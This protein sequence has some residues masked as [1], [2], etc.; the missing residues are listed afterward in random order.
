MEDF[1]MLEIVYRIYEVAEN[2]E[3]VKNDSF[4][5]DSISKLCSYEVAMDVCICESR[6]KFKDIIKDIYGKDIKFAYSRK[7]FTW[8]YLLHNNRRALL[9]Y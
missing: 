9:Q 2:P 7:I 3:D 6:D 5:I 8:H 1:N 4:G